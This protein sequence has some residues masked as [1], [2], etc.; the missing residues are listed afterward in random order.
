MN[1]LKV[2]KNSLARGLLLIFCL[3]AP[4]VSAQAAGEAVKIAYVEW[5]SEIA[6]ANVVKAVLQEKMGIRCEIVAMKADEMWQAVAEGEVDA[7]VGAWL[8]LTH[9]AYL[10]Q[11]KA[12]LVDLGPN[13]EGARIGLVVPNVSLGRQTAAT[14][15]RNTPYIKADSI[16]DLNKYGD[17]F[18]YRIIGIDPES[19]VMQKSR[20]A[21]EA[22]GLDNYELIPGSEVSM[23][24]ELAH[25]IQRQ[26]W[27]VVTGWL[28]HWKFA[29]WNLKFLKDP[30]GIYGGQESIH[31]MVREGFK[32]DRPEIYE[33]LDNFYWEPQDMG[34][35]MI[36][37]H[38]DD[39]MFPYEKAL[40]FLRGNEELVQSWLP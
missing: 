26:D 21:M 14:G 39:G 13:L 15:L 24:A 31:T 4:A 5:S 2:W 27:I 29:R 38:D 1:S 11:Y 35:L 6:S 9:S 23:T 12:D 40:R 8:P 19:G 36:W 16:S 34:Q 30:K 37:I 17:K 33:L 7:M 20:Q 25:A 32:L 3:A 10:K 22:Y 18:H 28:P